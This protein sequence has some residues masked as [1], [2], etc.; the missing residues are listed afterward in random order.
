MKKIQFFMCALLAGA[1]MFTACEKDPVV[2]PPPPTEDSTEVEDMPSLT[3]PGAGFVTLA[4]AVPEGTCNGLYAV[5][6]INSWAEKDFASFPFTK[7]A[8]TETWWEVKLPYAA[9]MQVKV[10]A[11]PQDES[12]VGW[13]YQWA[14]NIDPEDP[15]TTITEDHVILLNDNAEL[16]YEN[17]GQ[18]K[19]INAVDGSVVYIQVK[20][21]AS[22]PCVE[23]GIATEA[24]IKHPWNGGDW[25]YQQMEASATAG[26]F[27]YTARFGGNG[28]NIALD[29]TGKN[30]VWYPDFEG[31]AELAAGDSV[32]FTFVSEKGASGK[33]S[34]TL[35]EKGSD[36]PENPGE[37]KDITVKAKMPADWTNT[38][39][40]W[41]W[42]TGGE[43]SVYS[44]AAGNMTQ[45]GD[46]YV[47]TV[48]TTELNFIFRNGEDWA[49]DPNQTVDLKTSESA[50]YQIE[51]GEG[52]RNAT[53]IDC[54]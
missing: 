53:S 38:I 9:D 30:E 47:I 12:L 8:D 13:S 7:V 25:T 17:Q 41:V 46:W 2:V 5:G 54:E 16:T 10:L 51:A 52:K 34:A 15:D 1:M 43:G 28:V 40:A 18:P 39:T 24:W 48:N 20:A 36:E 33:V 3:E 44:V 22:E 19:L 14:K 49:G 37:P 26:T 4:I 27:T 45:E 50:C 23:L 11:K 42:P 32:L 29:G 21:W 35:I 31:F 6:T